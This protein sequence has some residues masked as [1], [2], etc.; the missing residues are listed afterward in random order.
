MTWHSAFEPLLTEMQVSLFELKVYLDDPE[1][2]GTVFSADVLEV[3]PLLWE[4]QFVSHPAATRFGT[5]ALQAVT[6]A[7]RR[8]ALQG[9]KVLEVDVAD[10]GEGNVRDVLDAL[11]Y[12]GCIARLKKCVPKGAG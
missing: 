9:L 8:G 3:M 4:V 7:L 10:L 6:A 11:Q 5:E 2:G 12:S 1:A